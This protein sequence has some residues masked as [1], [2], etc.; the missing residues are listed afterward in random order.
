MCNLPAFECPITVVAG[1][2]DMTFCVGLKIGKLLKLWNLNTA[3]AVLAFVAKIAYNKVAAGDVEAH[4]AASYAKAVHR[5]LRKLNTAMTGNLN[6]VNMNMRNQHREVRRTLAEQHSIV[7][8]LLTEQ[9]NSVGEQLTTQ[10]VVL[11]DN[12]GSLQNNL[13]LK[14]EEIMELIESKADEVQEACTLEG[15]II[16]EV[17]SLAIVNSTLILK[18][19]IAKS[20]AVLEEYMRDEIQAVTDSIQLTVKEIQSTADK[21]ADNLS[22]AMGLQVDAKCVQPPRI[23]SGSGS[24]KAIV[25]AFMVYTKS[26]GIPTNCTIDFVDVVFHDKNGEVKSQVASLLATTPL[27]EGSWRQHISISIDTDK[28]SIRN[29]NDILIIDIFVKSSSGMLTSQASVLPC[30]PS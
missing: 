8:N 7:A 18:E 5:N 14:H 16:R 27:P 3:G 22:S 9:H 11:N 28:N 1:A 6:I 15:L 13:Q 20:A 30:F 26:H 29:M 12:L 17:L 25:M 24:N 10:H 23:K 21:T 2:G 19:K 4:E